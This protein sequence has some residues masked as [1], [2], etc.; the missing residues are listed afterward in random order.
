MT[1]TDS[2]TLKE[3]GSAVLDIDMRYRLLPTIDEKEELKPTR[4]EAFSNYTS[5]RLKL[6]EEGVITTQEDLDEMKEIRS[7]I[8]KA[9]GLQ[10]I[11][12]A[13][14]RAAAFFAK[15]ALRA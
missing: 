10:T 5:L 7:E 9:A 15:L 4:D 3:A 11:L 8:E 1:D 13:A 6:L 14:G 2:L 12:V